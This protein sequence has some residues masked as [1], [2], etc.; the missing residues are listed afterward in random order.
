MLISANALRKLY[1]GHSVVL[2]QGYG[3]N[4][5][6]FP[7]ASVTPFERT[8]LV[9]NLVFIPLA[10]SLGIPGVLVDQVEYGAF[11]VSW[12]VRSWFFMRNYTSLNLPF[13]NSSLLCTVLQYDLLTEMLHFQAELTHKQY[14]V[15]YGTLSQYFIIHQGRP[16][17]QTQSFDISS[18]IWDYR[19]RR[20]LSFVS[21]VCWRLG[22]FIARWNLGLQPR[23]LEKGPCPLA[24]NS[25]SGLERCNSQ[26]RVQESITEGYL[27]LFT[28]QWATLP[29]EPKWSCEL[30]SWL[31]PSEF[32]SAY[33]DTL[34]LCLYNIHKHRKHWLLQGVDI[35]W[36]DAKMSK[37]FTQIAQL[38]DEEVEFFSN[39]GVYI[40]TRNI[41]KGLI[42][43]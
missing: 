6:G 9:T 32:L 25:E 37:S 5:L 41:F 35:S 12:N 15:T 36:F 28:G 1:P 13:S 29:S 27:Q 10:R 11:D 3:M 30:N 17:P 19:S 26:R 42:F 20:S 8:K 22:R 14:P 40:D 21:S 4:I 2:T 23:F 33:L 18:Y 34:L 24:G 31:N 7:A 43:L 16:I 38:Y 39:Y